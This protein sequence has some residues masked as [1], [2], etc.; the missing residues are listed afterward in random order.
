MI[1]MISSTSITS[2]SGVVLMSTTTSGSPPALSGDPTFMAMA[3]FLSAWD[4][5][6]PCGGGSVMKPTLKMPARWQSV[7]TLPT[8][9]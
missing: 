3:A 2:I 5:A 9:S 1:S 8:N 7:T 6:P 4:Q